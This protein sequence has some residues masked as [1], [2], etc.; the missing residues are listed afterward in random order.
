MMSFTVGAQISITAFPYTY[1]QDFA[2]F[3][4]TT[5]GLPAGWSASGTFT[6]RG[7][8]NG[9]SNAGGMWG[10][11]STAPEYALGALCSGTSSSINYK[12]SFR[13]N[14]ATAITSLTIS[15]DFEQWR[16]GGGNSNGFTAGQTG[17]G[18]SVAGLSNPSGVSSTGTPTVTPKSVTLNGLSI[19][20]NAVFEISWSI[21]DG[22]GTDNGVAIDNFR[23]TASSNVVLPPPVI[24]ADPVHDTTC[25]GA[26]ASFAVTA[27]NAAGYQWQEY[28]SSWNNLANNA[29]YSGVTTNTLNISNATGLN[30]RL[31]RAIATGSVNDTS[32]AA[33]LVVK[34]SPS[35]TLQPVAA[36][37][38]AGND[39][40]F[41]VAATGAGIT[42][43]W[44][45]NQGAG[46]INVTNSAVYQGATTSYLRLAQSNMTMNGYRYR[47]VVSGDCTPATSTDVLFTVTN[48]P[49]PAAPLFNSASTVFCNGDSV[50][51]S[52]NAGLAYQWRK[53]GANITGAT[54]DSLVIL[55]NG[56][57]C[58]AVKDGNGCRNVSDTLRVKVNPLPA[59]TITP[60][61]ATGICQKDSL[62]LQANAGT[63]L[64]YKWYKDG[65]I[66]PGAVNVSYTAGASG[67]YAV[68]VTDSN[69]CSRMS[70]ATTLTVNPLPSVVTSLSG[71]TTFC[72]GNTVTITVPTATGLT[73][74]WQRNNANVTSTGA[75]YTAGASGTYRVIVTNSVTGCKDTSG[76]ISVTVHPLPPAAITN[77]RPLAFCAGDSVVLSTT[78]GAGLTYKWLYNTFPVPG[79]TD[80]FFVAKASGNYA[81]VVTDANNCSRTAGVTVTAHPLPNSHITYNSPLEFCAD[82]AVV[83]ISSQDTGI[84][85]E[86]MKD[87]IPQGVTTYSNI[88]EQTG[89]YTVKQTNS[90]NCSRVSAGL[91]VTVWQKPI[92]VVTKNGIGLSTGYYV[93]YQW[94]VNNQPIGGGTSRTIT[95]TTNGGYNVE[96][97]DSNGCH[98]MSPIVFVNNVSVGQVKAADIRIYPNPVT[99]VLH[100]KAPFPVNVVLSDVQGRTVMVHDNAKDIELKSLPAGTYLLKVMDKTGIIIKIEMIT[101][102]GG[103]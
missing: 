29:V 69:G 103:N 36:T 80:T 44:Q 35:I 89:I 57:Y 31:Y 95:A 78:I 13:N 52:T 87:G 26:T 50:I 94:F 67:G 102:T 86:W 101:S 90:F 9:S 45:V 54:N 34:E 63:L 17:I 60:S 4:G 15:Y 68:Y 74:Q 93:S 12:V 37:V 20:P 40:G 8:G 99:D 23:L 65:T 33:T 39:T 10:Y 82:G 88:V 61:V 84:T 98:A 46:F 28:V 92:P 19:A 79:V 48:N 6:Q 73:Y 25:A 58:V 38:C 97:V 75:S 51:L 22:A 100:L 55:T 32:T 41:T 2:G 21:A 72:D 5:P 49:L 18:V 64:T 24:T 76:N 16:Y 85:Y 83:L 27:T 81:V 66:I 42:Y 56:L 77:T 96:V 14:A 11:G 3:N 59:A 71:V 47:C 53:D 70:A 1:T 91:P 62:R 7:Q 30:G 43:Q